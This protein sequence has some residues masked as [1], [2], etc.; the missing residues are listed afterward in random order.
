[1]HPIQRLLEMLAGEMNKDH[2]CGKCFLCKLSAQVKAELKGS[3][4]PERREEL[5]ILLHDV[6]AA[7]LLRA[8]VTRVSIPPDDEKPWR[9]AQLSCGVAA[10]KAKELGFPEA[11]ALY[12]KFAQFF[13]EIVPMIEDYDLELNTKRGEREEEKPLRNRRAGLNTPPSISL[14]RICLEKS[15]TTPTSHC[16]CIRLCPLMAMSEAEISARLVSLLPLVS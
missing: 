13:T 12:Q 5:S 15:L 16:P 4:T 9:T 1:M 14:T 10:E 11:A 2:N 7:D 8:R 6:D 3:T